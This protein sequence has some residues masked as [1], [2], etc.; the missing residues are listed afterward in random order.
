MVTLTVGYKGGSEK[1]SGSGC[2]LQAATLS[3]LAG[4]KQQIKVIW[5]GR[6]S[7]TWGVPCMF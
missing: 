4:E 5:E 6:G 2:A 3:G 1:R 7:L